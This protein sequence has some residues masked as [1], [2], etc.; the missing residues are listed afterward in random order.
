MSVYRP[1]SQSVSSLFFYEFVSL[2][3]QISL[4]KCPIVVCG[5]FNIHVD[6]TTDLHAVRFLQ[7]LESFACRQHVDTLTHIAG[8]T[9][10]LVITRRESAVHMVKVRDLISDHFLIAFK[11]CVKKIIVEQA[12]HGVNCH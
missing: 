11:L 4:F 8:H 1:G 6:D 5:D 7:L 2:L 3:E 9:L 10:D 12:V